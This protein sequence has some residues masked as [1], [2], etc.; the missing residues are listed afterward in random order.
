MK[1]NLK[2]YN[3]NYCNFKEFYHKNK[4]FCNSPET[5]FKL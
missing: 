4:E 1:E 3:K 5:K 2:F